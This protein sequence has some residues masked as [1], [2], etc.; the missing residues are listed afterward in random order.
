M[1]GV[2]SYGGPLS[3]LPGQTVSLVRVQAAYELFWETHLLGRLV[4]PGGKLMAETRDGRWELRHRSRLLARIQALDAEA[5]DV[6]LTF[7]RRWFGS[8]GSIR[9]AAATSYGLDRTRFSGDWWLSGPGNDR[10]MILR[11][12]G[13][14]RVDIGVQ[15][16]GELP[17]EL[18]LLALLSSYVIL[19]G[20]VPSNLGPPGGASSRD[21]PL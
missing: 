1:G 16:G 18:G 9:D 15:A 20:Q 13:L 4:R 2:P 19:L 12:P 17:P 14:Q 6:A 8:G 3:E 11:S 5:H 7:T 21:L 10:L